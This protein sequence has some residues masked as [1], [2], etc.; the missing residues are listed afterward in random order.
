MSVIIPLP[1]EVSSIA[2][3]RNLRVVH[4][5]RALSNRCRVRVVAADARIAESARH[6]WPDAEMVVA[7]RDGSPYSGSPEPAMVNRAIRFF[8]DDEALAATVCGQVTEAD[9]V[10]GFGLSSTGA[11]LAASRCVARPRVVCDLIDDPWLTWKAQSIRQRLGLEGLKAA[12][13]IRLV[14]RRVLPRFDALVAVGPKDARALSLVTGRE[15][16]V[17]ANGVSIDDTA[18]CA[19]TTEPLAVFTGAM[20][21]PPNVAAARFF[22]RRIWPRLRSACRERGIAA[23]LAIVGAD[24]TGSVRRLGRIEGVTV[25][26]R[27]GDV[28]DWLRRARVAVAPMVSGSGIKNK[29]LEACAAGCPVIASP[30]GALG[31]PTGP[32]HGVLLASSVDEWVRQALRLLTWSD[33]ARAVGAAGRAMVRRHFSWEMSARRLEAVLGIVAGDDDR[34]T[35]ERARAGSVAPIRRQTRSCDEEAMIHA[36]S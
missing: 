8:G 33:E 26:G 17:I 5:V 35:T 4:L 25:T 1:F 19:G 30:L 15:V 11:L 10:L 22:A 6:Q 18:A 34:D 16:T 20:D 31:L 3:G 24:P 2:H 27:V 23:S 9:A 28:G 29:V 36:A 7:S 32:E 21:F 13:S 14:R 12:V